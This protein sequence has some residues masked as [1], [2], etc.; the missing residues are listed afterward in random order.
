LFSFISSELSSDFDLAFQER[1]TDS[2]AEINKIIPDINQFTVALWVRTSDGNPGV[3]LSYACEDGGKVQDNALVIQDCGGVNL[4]INNITAFL[5]VDIN[6]G[7][8]HHFAVTWQ[9]STG[10][11]I[12]VLF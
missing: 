9:S 12:S 5:S 3:P 6:D 1:V 4:I 8:W 10:N 2:Y 11:P 7:Y